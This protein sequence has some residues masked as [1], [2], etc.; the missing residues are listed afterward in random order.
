MVHSGHRQE[1]RCRQRYAHNGLAGCIQQQRSSASTTG[2]QAGMEA[3]PVN[4]WVTVCEAHHS[5]AA[6]S[7][8]ALAQSHAADPRGWCEDCRGGI[9]S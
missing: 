9:P 3:D 8:L 4:P 7:S 1:L 2:E 5:V 6:H